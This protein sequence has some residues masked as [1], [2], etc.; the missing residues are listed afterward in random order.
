MSSLIE[1]RIENVKYGNHFLWMGIDS[2]NNLYMTFPAIENILEYRADSAREKLSSKKLRSFV[3]K[4]F[5]LGKKSAKVANRPSGF[6]VPDNGKVSV[7]SFDGFLQLV[8]WEVSNQ[9]PI[10][11]SLVVTGLGDSLRSLALKQFGVA[12]AEE[13]RQI[14][15]KDR[16]ASKE[17]FWELGEAIKQYLEK[18]PERSSDYR[19]WVYLNCQDK[20][21][22]G[23]FGKSAKKIRE[24]L[25]S[26]ANLLRDNYGSKAL[27]R[28]DVVQRLACRYITKSDIEP[29]EAIAKAVDQFSY[30]IINYQD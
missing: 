30:G 6:S 21:N 22:R 15:I 5:Q 16:H 10:A 7:I 11:I 24:E 25:G 19:T 9:N 28:L 29:K 8:F 26:V 3:N 12:V 1:I 20:I 23:L 4:N 17:A 13:D 18:H 27:K 2:F 14:W